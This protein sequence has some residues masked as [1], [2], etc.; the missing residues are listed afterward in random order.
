MEYAQRTWCLPL[1]S[2]QRF[3]KL[4]LPPRATSENCVDTLLTGSSFI[5]PSNS[6]HMIDEID[7]VDNEGYV[8]AYLN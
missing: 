5:D 2:I 3:S 6:F 7:N 4:N 8:P 1:P